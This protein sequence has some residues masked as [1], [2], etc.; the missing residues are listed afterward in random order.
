M[1]T[2]THYQ[3]YIK[4]RLENDPEFRAKYMKQRTEIQSRRYKRDE[5]FKAQHDENVKRRHRQRYAE[6]PEYCE[7]K[8]TMALERYYRLKALKSAEV[9]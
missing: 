6:D 1:E 9:C 5:T 3:K 4:P 8:K 7:R 2:L